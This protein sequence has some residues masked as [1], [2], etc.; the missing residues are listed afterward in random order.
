MKPLLEDLRKYRKNQN[1]GRNGQNSGSNLP[2][3]LYFLV[4]N[5]IKA[6]E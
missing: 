5:Q 6:Y 2:K 4:L 1:Y 3:S